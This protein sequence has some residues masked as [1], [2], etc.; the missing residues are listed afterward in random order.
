[1]ASNW[2]LRT[3]AVS[4]TYFQPIIA[5]AGVVYMCR[6]LLTKFIDNSG[7]TELSYKYYK[8]ITNKYIG[9]TTS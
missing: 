9:F 6:R 1:M 4:G 2:P 3:L 7:K 5:D 8:I